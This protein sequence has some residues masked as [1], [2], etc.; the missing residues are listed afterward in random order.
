[1]TG[2]GRDNPERVTHH[3]KTP[4]ASVENVKALAGIVSW[5]SPP[6]PPTDSPLTNDVDAL[7]AMLKR[8]RAARFIYRVHHAQC[9][10]A[11][12]G[13]GCDECDELLEAVLDV[14]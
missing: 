7:Q 9:M 8:Y 3:P 6:I 5:T 13:R 1:M 12:M 2:V 10:R 11:M 4:G 14:D